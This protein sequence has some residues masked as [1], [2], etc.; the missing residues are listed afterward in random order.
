[1]GLLLI[2]TSARADIPGF[3]F[4]LEQAEKNVEIFVRTTGAEFFS[5]PT[6]EVEIHR[7]QGSGSWKKLFDGDLGRVDVDCPH[8]C[9]PDGSGGEYCYD[10]CYDVCG[11]F[12]DVC[13][14]PGHY[15]YKVTS[16]TVPSP[17]EPGLH[18]QEQTRDITVTESATGV[19]E[20]PPDAAAH[21]QDGEGCGCSSRTGAALPNLL[22]LALMLLGGGFL[23]IRHRRR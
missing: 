20:P 15:T 14:E 5:P 9:Y 3:S 12:V 7:R 23:T 1:V 11:T 10:Y 6:C 13:P 2:P 16:H 4:Q 22:L 18:T 17:H 21:H 8:V 19:C